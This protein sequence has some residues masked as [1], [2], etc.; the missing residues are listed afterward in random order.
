MT[1]YLRITLQ[2]HYYKDIVKLNFGDYV[3][4]HVPA[5][6]TNNNGTRTTGAI[7][8]YPSGNA[9]GSWYFMSLETGKRIHR[10]DWDILPI[11][12]DVLDR[13]EAIAIHEG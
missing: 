5:N 1:A 9:Q 10:Y 6:K 8:L 12:K 2:K 13:V 11:S 7:A 3:Q 4:T